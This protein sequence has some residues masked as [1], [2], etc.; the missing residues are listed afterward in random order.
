MYR[1]E[2]NPLSRYPEGRSLEDD[3]GNWCVAHLKSR[4]EKQFAKTL[5]EKSIS[6]YLPLYVKTTRRKDNNKQ[7][8]SICPLFPGYL[9]LA[10]GKE[11][12][13]S[14]SNNSDLVD[15]IKV[16][17]QERFIKELNQIREII[18]RNLSF[19]LHKGLTPGT[20]VK[21]KNGQLEGMEGV[22]VK[23]EKGVRLIIGIEMFSQFI[24]VE[25][26]ESDVTPLEQV[27]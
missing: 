9:A 25:I 14:I 26:N 3:K 5:V 10:S 2:D 13:H 15:I 1:K 17:D 4:R 11:K 27:K 18:D 19:H 23:D 12:I 16:T 7:R 6:Y 20:K 22:V 24:S 21:V 8:K